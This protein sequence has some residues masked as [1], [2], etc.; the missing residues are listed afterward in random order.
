MMSKEARQLMMSG[1][2]AQGLELWKVRSCK[3]LCSES[4]ES[5]LTTL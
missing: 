5:P 3:F 1:L 4:S 2:G